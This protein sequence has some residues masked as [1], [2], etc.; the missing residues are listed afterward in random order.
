MTGTAL[1]VVFRAADAA[2]SLVYWAW[3]DDPD[4]RFAVLDGP[5]L[6]AALAAL[7]EALSHGEADV[8]AALTSGAFA[9]RDAE[10]ALV[11]RLA[12]CVLPSRFREEVLERAAGSPVTIRLTV[13]QRL[14]RVP[15]EVLPVDGTGRRLVEVATLRYEVPATI[16]HR[17]GRLPAEWDPAGSPLRI[18]DPYV[19]GFPSLLPD[20]RPGGRR[21]IRLVLGPDVRAK[22]SFTR[23]QL[24]EELQRRPSRLL[25]FGHATSRPDDPGSA[26]LHLSDTARVAGQVEAVGDHRPF[27][28]LDLLLGTLYLDPAQ[29]RPG[30]EVWPMPPRV[31]LIACH[32]GADQSAVET[33]GLVVAALNAGAEYVTS[34]RWVLPTDTAFPATRWFPTTELMLRVDAAHD[35]VDL[36]AAIRAWQLARLKR[37]RAR[38]AVAD[39]PL[40]WAALTTHHA[41]RR[42]PS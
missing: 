4:P 10:A 35:R 30:H 19:R 5:S 8:A 33:F 42:A 28:A 11:A 18:L 39:S 14:A 3:L 13:S 21:L 12:A 1:E 23:R 26:A 24:A 9:S 25:Y 40:L 22:P 38:G 41:P 7:E 17:R 27:A 16:H 31:A 29:P 34:T 6:T 37:W 20:D 2:D 36:V 15:W 32:S